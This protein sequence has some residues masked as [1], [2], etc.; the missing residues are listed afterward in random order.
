MTA[1]YGEGPTLRHARA[2]LHGGALL[3]AAASSRLAD[4][5]RSDSEAMVEQKQRRAAYEQWREHTAAE[6]VRQTGL[7][8]QLTHSREEFYAAIDDEHLWACSRCHETVYPTCNA[9]RA[10]EPTQAPCPYCNPSVRQ[11]SR[12]Q[13]ALDPPAY[14]PNEEEYQ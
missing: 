8:K 3:D 6:R 13:Q 2:T 5:A 14:L 11:G 4:R 7:L 1:R 12:D 9:T 10:G